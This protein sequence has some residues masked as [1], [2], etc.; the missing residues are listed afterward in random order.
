MKNGNKRIG[1]T[2]IEL[3]VVI[4]IIAVLA[5]I[6]APSAFLAIEKSKVARLF[7]DSRDIATGAYHMYSDTG[8]WPGSNWIDDSVANGGGDPLAGANPGEGFVTAPIVQNVPTWDGPYIEKWAKNP[9][10]GWYYWDF[11][12]AS[13]NGDGIGHQHVLWVDNGGSPSNSSYNNANFRIPLTA[14]QRFDTQMD[15]GNLTTGKIQV[16]QGDTTTGNLGY[17]LI[18]GE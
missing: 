8:M 10:G 12:L 13:Q 15:D 18:E 2:L 16:W 6:V 7:A 17:I 1:F 4:A 5:A 14:R 9:W 3:I 11:N